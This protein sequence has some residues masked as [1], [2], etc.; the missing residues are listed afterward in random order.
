[1]F[2]VSLIIAGGFMAYAETS[3]SAAHRLFVRL[4]GQN[5]GGEWAPMCV[6]TVRSV[7][8]GVV[9]VAAIQAGLCAI[10]LFSLGIPGA[11]I[12]SALILL[13]AIAQL[14][15]VIVIAPIVVYAFSHYQTTPAIIFT[16][17]MAVAAVSDTFLKPLLMGRGLGIP[18]PFILMGAIGGMIAAGIIGLFA[19]AVV[20]AIWYKL[21]NSWLEQTAIDAA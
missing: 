10:G 20:L 11:P 9:G 14:P 8:Q 1:M 6:A 13:L 4:G 12:W 17:W 15:T 16:I 7:L 5:P 21:F 19:G 18:M 3:A 2:V